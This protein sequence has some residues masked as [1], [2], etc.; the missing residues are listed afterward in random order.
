MSDMT[1]DEYQDATEET[2]IYPVVEQSFVYPALGL[3]GESGEVLDKIKKLFRDKKGL[4]LPE[5][6]EEIK[7][8]L[9]DVLWYLAR[10]AKE[11]DIPMSEVANC[12]L[13]KLKSRSQRGKISGSGDNR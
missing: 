4:P 12:N 6:K 11:F 2:A 8:E 1:L 5:D 7:K 13:D 10:L 9:G 3:A